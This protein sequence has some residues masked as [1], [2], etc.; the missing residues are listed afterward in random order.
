[1][2]EMIIIVEKFFTPLSILPRMKGALGFP[3]K[4]HIKFSNIHS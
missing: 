3:N 1:M 2:N 4:P